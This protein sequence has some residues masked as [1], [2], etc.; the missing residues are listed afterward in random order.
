MNQLITYIDTAHI[1]V[2]AMLVSIIWIIQ[3]LH[4]PTFRYIES[5][6]ESEFHRFHTRSISFIVGPLMVIELLMASINL[7]I[8]LEVVS[9]ILFVIVIIIW[10]STFLIQVPIHNKLSSNYDQ[11][12]VNRLI[13]TNWIRTS[14]WTTKFLIMIFISF[15]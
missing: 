1:I 15:R 14:C 12:L 8:D 11:S 4:Y 9:T 10:L 5:N 13:K 7:Y 3:V 6:I 2:T